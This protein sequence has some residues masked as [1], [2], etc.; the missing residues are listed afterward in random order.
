MTASVT[1]A[2][3]PRSGDRAERRGAP[4]ERLLEQLLTSL[5]ART[6]EGSA[7]WE[8]DDAHEDS[9]CTIGHGW[10]V[11]TRS[12]DGDGA[13]PYAV[14]VSGPSGAPVVSVTSVSPHG[15]PLVDL[16]PRLHAAAAATATMS[17]AAPLLM[18]I[19]EEIRQTRS[20]GRRAPGRRRGQS[21]SA[22]RSRTQASMASSAASG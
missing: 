4:S 11:A 18:S 2:A 3:G 21:L 13:A 20:G 1:S 10:L 8:V 12:V 15:R 5:L 22:S 14:V 9:F 7:D 6:E 17:S 16:F 19:V